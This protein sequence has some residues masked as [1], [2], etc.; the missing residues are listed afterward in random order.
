MLDGGLLVAGATLA[1]AQGRDAHARRLFETVFELDPKAVSRRA[2][3]V[4]REWLVL[5]AAEGGDW[6]RAHE[7]ASSGRRTR[8]VRF[9]GAVA[10]IAVGESSRWPELWW[11]LAPNRRFNTRILERVRAHRERLARKQKPAPRATAA[12]SEVASA[13]AALRQY[14]E[15]MARADVDA[16]S[17]LSTIA[18]AEALDGDADLRHRARARSRALGIED[19]ADEAVRELQRAIRADLAELARDQQLPLDQVRD[20]GALGIEVAATLRDELMGEVE[21]AFDALADRV[22][23]DRKLPP[24]DELA[25]WAALVDSYRAAVGRGGD[26][27]QLLWPHVHPIACD[28]GVWLHRSSRHR[29]SGNAV[30]RFLLDEAQLL[31]DVSAIELQ[32]SNVDVG[33]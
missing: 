31:E 5:D 29:V 14:V 22:A 17:V 10:A 28:Y 3:H 20:A 19:Q 12:A 11:L 23:A 6:Q 15:V 33:W 25:E 7:L 18:G 13:S 8:L 4:A 27:R 26:V 2:E 24:V 1:L 16:G 32:Q 9:V 30:F 21:V